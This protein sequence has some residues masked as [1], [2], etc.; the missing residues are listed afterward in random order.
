MGATDTPTCA[1]ATRIP[2]RKTTVPAMEI[3]TSFKSCEIDWSEFFRARSVS[4]RA[5]RATH[6]ATISMMTKRKIESVV[7]KPRLASQFLNLVVAS[8]H[9]NVAT[10]V[11]TS[12]SAKLPRS[13]ISVRRMS[14]VSPPNRSSCETTPLS[15]STASCSRSDSKRAACMRSASVP[16]A[17]WRFANICNP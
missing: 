6:R 15:R 11:S 16:S 12:P 3:S 8:A 1:S 2:I 4:R 9:S 13:S 17:A 14:T 5:T 10:S 7:D